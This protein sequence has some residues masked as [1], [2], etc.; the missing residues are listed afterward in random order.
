VV[1]VGVLVYLLRTLS[2]LPAYH[3]RRRHRMLLQMLLFVQLLRLTRIA[4]HWV[5]ASHR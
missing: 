2:L 4:D 1:H 5:G 3:H